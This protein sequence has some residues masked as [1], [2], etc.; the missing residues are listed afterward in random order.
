MISVL[1]G[2]EKCSGI[3]LGIDKPYFILKEDNRERLIYLD[4]TPQLRQLYYD[5]NCFRKCKVR[6]KSLNHALCWIRRK[7]IPFSFVHPDNLR[8][9]TIGEIKMVFV[10]EYCLSDVALRTMSTEGNVIINL[11]N[12]NGSGCISNA[13]YETGAHMGITLLTMDEFYGYINKIATKAP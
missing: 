5:N 3:E 1:I 9:I 4:D 6:L 11:H 8:I 2:Q 10:Y 7:S 13:A 12:W